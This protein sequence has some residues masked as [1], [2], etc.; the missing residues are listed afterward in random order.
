MD[1]NT[2]GESST[3]ESNLTQTEVQANDAASSTSQ[4]AQTVAPDANTTTANSSVAG[5]NNGA[6]APENLLAAVRKAVEPEA[7]TVTASPA[8]EAKIGTDGKPIEAT[9]K[10]GEGAASASKPEDDPSLPFHNHPRWKQVIAERNSAIAERDSFKEDATQYRQIDGYMKQHELTPNEVAQGFIVMAASKHD[11]VRFLQLIQPYYDQAQQFVG[12]VLPPDLKDQVERGL[13][14]ND[15]AKELV[16]RRNETALYNHREQKNRQQTQAQQQQ[17]DQQR[18]QNE[19]V[20]QQQS[21]GKAV[22][23][24]ETGLKTRD[25][26]YATNADKQRMVLDRLTV[27]ARE[28]PPKNPAEGVALAQKA[29]D[30]INETLRKFSPTRT[31]I[32]PLTSVN[33]PA[34][35]KAAPTSLLDVVR[36]VA[37]GSN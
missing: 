23:D 12:A 11:P 33:S 20:T 2:Q 35:V 4:A 28:N 1:A 14:T 15:A 18:Q 29:Y 17:Q 34:A 30:E 27:I 31:Q 3:P 25:P 10:P 26:D 22:S 36:Q 9:P 21:I 24:W 37:N 6:K 7:S 5:E 19:F 13:I 32:K 8:A 16:R